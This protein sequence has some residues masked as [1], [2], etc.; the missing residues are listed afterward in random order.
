MPDN[1]QLIRYNP[2][3]PTYE[4]F[5]GD[6]PIPNQPTRMKFNVRGYEG[7]GF[8]PATPQGRAAT[9]YAAVAR[10]INIGSILLD[11][12]VAR[13]WL[14]KDPMWP[15]TSNLTVMPEAGKMWN[16][17]YNRNSLRFYY[18][19][20]AIRHKT[21]YT[22]SSARIVSHES[23]HGLLDSLRPDLWGY[24]NF[25]V[26]SFHEAFGDVLSTVLALQDP[27]VASYMLS[28]NGGNL[29]EA[30][31]VSGLGQEFGTAILQAPLNTIIPL[32]ELCNS[33]KWTL[34]GT[35]PPKA[36][37]SELSAEPHSFSRIFSGACYDIMVG[38]FEHLR[39]QPH[40]NANHQLYMDLQDA[41]NLMGSYLITA[42]SLAPVNERFFDC[43][44]KA[45]IFVDIQHQ[46]V[47]KDVLYTVFNDRKILQ[48]APVTGQAV[49]VGYGYKEK[50]HQCKV[51]DGHV[52]RMSRTVKLNDFI[53]IQ[54]TD[55]FS[56]VNVDIAMDHFQVDDHPEL[57]II[58]DKDAALDSAH[59]CV[60]W[61]Q[62]QK[63][64]RGPHSQFKLKDGK[65]IRKHFACCFRT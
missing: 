19:I 52:R 15:K 4:Q 8:D 35:L 42:A 41:A 53:H 14:G 61:V 48:P 50:R 23:G 32:R 59:T 34:P 54:T 60:Y 11:R 37:D 13:D 57:S 16:A 45:M 21:I 3:D 49:G 39:N 5:Y 31:V 12:N 58:S 28:Q 9:C 30:N 26:W 7:G 44:A 20:D 10:T 17:F 2:L 46:E 56:N 22:S 47:Y 18:N 64:H 27:L 55:E 51:A 63:K 24:T 62:D 40:A 33:Y 29:K 36:P 1:T 38:L 6:M 65:L 43:V 25:E